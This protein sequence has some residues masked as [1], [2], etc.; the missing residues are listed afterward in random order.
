MIVCWKRW[1]CLRDIGNTVIVGRNAM[2]EDAILAADYLSIWD[3][4][5]ATRLIASP[6]EPLHMF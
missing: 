1:N 2:T 6:S 3:P 4:A 5:L